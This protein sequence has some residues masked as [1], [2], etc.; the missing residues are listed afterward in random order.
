M[1]CPR[2]RSLSGI[3]IAERSCGNGLWPD[4]QRG[5]RLGAAVQGV[6]AVFSGRILALDTE[7]A[8]HCADLALRARARGHGFPTEDDTI[9]ATTASHRHA[10]AVRDTAP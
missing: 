6:M 4:G 10:V 8:R 9:A 1:L 2:R 7:A 3:T 5:D